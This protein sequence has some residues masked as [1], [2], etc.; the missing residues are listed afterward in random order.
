LLSLSLLDLS[1]GNV[2]A[3]VAGSKLEQE[4]AD[5]AAGAAAREREGENERA[6]N[7]LIEVKTKLQY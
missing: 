7:Q 5:E 2:G 6:S 4:R 1:R 3:A